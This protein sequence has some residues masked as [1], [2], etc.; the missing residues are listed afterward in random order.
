MQKAE[1]LSEKKPVTDRNDEVPDLYQPVSIQEWWAAPWF[2]T[3]L[4][5]AGH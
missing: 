2:A 1:T 5:L 4:E 3:W